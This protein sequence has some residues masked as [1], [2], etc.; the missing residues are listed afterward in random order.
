MKNIG[1]AQL[2]RY[3]LESYTPETGSYDYVIEREIQISEDAVE[4]LSEPDNTETHCFEWVFVGN[5]FQQLQALGL[6]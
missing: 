6:R 4:F 2:R 5:R 3:S 1:T